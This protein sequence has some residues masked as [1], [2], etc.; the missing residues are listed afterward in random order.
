L[1]RKLPIIHSSWLLACGDRQ[2]LVPWQEYLLNAISSQSL[3]SAAKSKFQK[4]QSE[5]NLIVKKARLNNDF[6]SFL[7]D[8]L[9]GEK[10]VKQQ[11]PQRPVASVPDLSLLMDTTS[12]RE[13]F[14]KRISFGN[15]LFDGCFF[16]ALGFTPNQVLLIELI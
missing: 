14:S 16:K 2:R 5:P 1:P 11:V 6:D 9:S 12:T 4:H 3:P 10:A 8:I 13:A 15:R 7:G